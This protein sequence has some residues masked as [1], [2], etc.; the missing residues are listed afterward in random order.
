LRPWG[1]RS[2]FDCGFVEIPSSGK[3]GQKWGTRFHS[4]GPKPMRVLA[5]RRG[6]RM[7]P[8]LHKPGCESF[9]IWHSFSSNQIATLRG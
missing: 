1:G 7:R 4:W 6:G 2:R 5:V 8:P 3:S 9:L